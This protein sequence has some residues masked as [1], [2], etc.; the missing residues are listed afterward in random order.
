MDFILNTAAWVW[1]PV[2]RG[3][4][5]TGGRVMPPYDTQGAVLTLGQPTGGP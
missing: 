4:R 2:T 5:A 1:E 3:L